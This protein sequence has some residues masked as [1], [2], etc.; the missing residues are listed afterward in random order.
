MKLK[1]VQMQG[2]KITFLF[3][4]K[5]LFLSI[6]CFIILFRISVARFQQ[7]SKAIEEAFPGERKE[8]YYIPWVKGAEGPLCA[9]GIL[10]DSYTNRRKVLRQ[11]GIITKTTPK[12]THVENNQIDN[13]DYV[14]DALHYLKNN[15]EPITEIQE[16][17]K[18]THKYRLLHI[19]K[20]L[21]FS[22]TL[23]HSS[24][25]KVLQGIC[26]LTKI[27]TRCTQNVQIN[28]SASGRQ[29]HR[30]LLIALSVEMMQR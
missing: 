7:L 26:C 30:N 1:I 12:S 15:I 22:S 18:V 17:W 2:L 10:Y 9:R 23:T 27:S 8:V 25:F 21:R 13:E 11:I 16:K 20:I 3:Q 24:A 19:A 6:K 28:C 5:L 29:L 14:K 4:N